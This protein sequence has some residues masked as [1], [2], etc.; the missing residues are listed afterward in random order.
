LSAVGKKAILP[1]KKVSFIK[2]VH[3]C[4]YYFPRE[5]RCSTP[6]LCHAD[7]L[8]INTTDGALR[9]GELHINVAY[10]LDEKLHSLLL[11][12]R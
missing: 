12:V 8:T 7:L 3:L 10:W 4:A 6:I 2:S 1:Y 5:Q 9:Q 11:S